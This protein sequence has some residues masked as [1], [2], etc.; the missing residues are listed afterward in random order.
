MD[1][2]R[3]ALHSDI[4]APLDGKAYVEKTV[5]DMASLLATAALVRKA[6]TPD[7]AG[8]KSLGAG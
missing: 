7:N 3:V 5:A 4:S 1:P 6:G 2:V 8:I